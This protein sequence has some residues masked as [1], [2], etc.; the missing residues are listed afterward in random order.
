[1]KTHLV[2]IM[3]FNTSWD[4]LCRLPEVMMIGSLSLKVGSSL[5]DFGSNNNFSGQALGFPV[6]A[7]V[8]LPLTGFFL[9]VI[10]GFL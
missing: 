4:Q 9:L 8:L 2:C 5:T 10:L 6:V 7:L 1:M 3:P